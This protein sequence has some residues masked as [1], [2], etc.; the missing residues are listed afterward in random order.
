MYNTVSVQ[1]PVYEGE[2]AQRLVVPGVAIGL[3]WTP[4]GGEIMFVEASA[5]QGEGT[6]TLTG[7]LGDVMKVSAT[8]AQNWVKAHARQ[9]G[10]NSPGPVFI[11]KLK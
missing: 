2:I 4:M 1:Q 8:L 10:H 3:A 9:V 6:L 11:K 5:I 7:Q